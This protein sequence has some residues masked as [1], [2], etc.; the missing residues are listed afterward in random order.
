MRVI[1]AIATHPRA[2]VKK[3]PNNKLPQPPRLP[4]LRRSKRRLQ[5]KRPVK[6]PRRSKQRKKALTLVT[7][8][9]ANQTEGSKPHRTVR[10][11]HPP[12]QVQMTRSKE[13]RN[14]HE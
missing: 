2:K 3:R 9:R 4:P 14:D 10:T 7:K 11:N 6:K 5:R 1:R 12:T 8:A 13:I